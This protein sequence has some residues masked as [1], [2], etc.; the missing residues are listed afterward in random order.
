MVVLN[1]TLFCIVSLLLDIVALSFTVR[2][3]HTVMVVL[4]YY[5][6][7]SV[8]VSLTIKDFVS[9][10]LWFWNLSIINEVVSDARFPGYLESHFNLSAGLLLIQIQSFTA[11]L[12]S[13]SLTPLSFSSIHCPHQASRL[14]EEH[15]WGCSK[16]KML[17]FWAAPLW[18]LCVQYI[19][20]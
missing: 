1:K 3:A 8:D 9:C 16:D 14:P 15:Q 10:G 5:P 11:R 13:V 4:S 20:V 19:S 17:L 6:R 2:C 12:C 7:D 18:V